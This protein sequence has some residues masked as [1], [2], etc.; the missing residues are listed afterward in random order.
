M[1]KIL[2]I[3]SNE[4]F[5]RLMIKKETESY[6]KGIQLIRKVE[7]LCD[8]GNTY[9]GEYQSIKLGRTKSCGCLKKETDIK[10]VLKRNTTHS[11]SVRG[12]RTPEYVCWF[13]MIQRCNNPNNTRYNIYGGRGIT[14]CKRWMKFEN[15][16]ADMGKR[17]S[18][19]YSIDRIDVNGNY[20]P[21]NCRWATPKEQANNRR[22]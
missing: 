12:K 7:C 16:L 14:V 13:N 2:I 10:R 21:N 17:P 6:Y 1:G 9:I 19:I 3:K 20:K 18:P 22:K 5:N 8:C 15:F 11:N 4:K